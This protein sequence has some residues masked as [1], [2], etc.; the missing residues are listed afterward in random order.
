MTP[1][2]VVEFCRDLERV[3]H[4]HI[5][6]AFLRRGQGPGGRERG[7]WR[8]CLTATHT[9]GVL[10]GTPA[11]RT[12]VYTCVT[13]ARTTPPRDAALPLGLQHQQ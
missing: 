2:S 6:T 9:D 12:L 11:F 8:G 3:L 5:Q 4:I 10:A 7:G 1:G 13:C